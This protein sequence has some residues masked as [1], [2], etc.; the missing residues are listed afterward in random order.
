MANMPYCRF[1][2][3]V[4]DLQDCFD[5]FDDDLESPE[6]EAR[7]KLYALCEKIVSWYDKPE[8]WDTDE[9]VNDD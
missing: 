5:N 6:K 9:E 1:E 8:I 7:R 4:E 2:N 3:T